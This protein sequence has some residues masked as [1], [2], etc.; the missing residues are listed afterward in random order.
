VPSLDLA[1]A[2]AW[3]A[4]GLEECA[5]IADEDDRRHIEDDLRSISS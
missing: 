2:A 3:K 1:E 4:L 5:R